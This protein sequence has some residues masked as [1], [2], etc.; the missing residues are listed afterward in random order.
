MIDMPV[1]VFMLD[2]WLLGHDHGIWNIFS[3]NMGGNF[4]IFKFKVLE[5]LVLSCDSVLSFS[6]AHT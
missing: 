3:A 2:T 1:R 5:I 6:Q 4:S